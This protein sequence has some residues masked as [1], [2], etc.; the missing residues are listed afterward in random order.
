[1]I[2]GN[3]NMPIENLK[4]VL[5]GNVLQDSENGDDK[6]V[7]LNNGDSLIV[8]F[9]PKPPPKHFRDEFDDDDDDELRF[10][11]PPSTSKWKRKFFH[12]LRDK[13]KFP[14]KALTRCFHISY[15]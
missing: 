8:A 3:R 6:V 15:R 1:M 5:R 2:A 10:Q 11:L 7:Q 4:L 9:K 14:G 12:I 13:L